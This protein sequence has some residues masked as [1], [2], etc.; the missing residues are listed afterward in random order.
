[1]EPLE[2]VPLP[3]FLQGYFL[4]L[5]KQRR[6]NP[7]GVETC[8]KQM[9]TDTYKHT[10]WTDEGKRRASL[11]S[12]LLTE[13]NFLAGPCVTSHFPHVCPRA[14][15][16]CSDTCTLDRYS[17]IR[18][19]PLWSRSYKLTLPASLP[20]LPSPRS[21]CFGGGHP[22]IKSLSFHFYFPSFCIIY[23]PIYSQLWW[24]DNIHQIR[25][26]QILLET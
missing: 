3:F 10:G 16:H 12:S 13:G 14:C 20:P 17:W 5:Q 11:T 25:M 1:M 21:I 8:S 6:E 24:P 19:L 26:Y 23:L 7:P 18:L 2:S 9:D 15:F 22:L 4:H